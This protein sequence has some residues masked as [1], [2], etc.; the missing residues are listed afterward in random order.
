MTLIHAASAT[1]AEGQVVTQTSRI[2]S[3]RCRMALDGIMP[4]SLWQ[5]TPWGA[6]HGFENS[7]FAVI[8]IGLREHSVLPQEHGGRYRNFRRGQRR[9][10][11]ETSCWI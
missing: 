10:R 9:L 8:V 11:G 1:T 6:T 2:V 3:R 5:Q 4:G 7:L